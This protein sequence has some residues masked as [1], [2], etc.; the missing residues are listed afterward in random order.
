MVQAAHG[1]A[2]VDPAA[3][4]AALL[5][6]LRSL[7]GWLGLADIRVARRGDLAPAVADAVAR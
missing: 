4:A 7:A 3:V 2:G 1:E 6:E 5:P